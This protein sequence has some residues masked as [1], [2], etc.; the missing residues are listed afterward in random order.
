MAIGPIKTSELK[1]RILQ[2]AQTSVYQIKLSPPAAVLSHLRQNGFDYAADG[3]NMEL[4]CNSAV[5]PGSSLKTHDIVGDFQGV[6]EKMAYQRMYDES[7]DLTFYV[8]HDYK[9]I[10]LFDGWL[11]YISGQGSGQRLSK[12][13]ALKPSANYRMNYPGYGGDIGYKTNMSIVKF[14]KDVSTDRSIFEDDK[15]FQ[16]TYT[17]VNAFPKTIVSTPISYEGNQ[18]LKYS[19]SMSIQRYV[20]RVDRIRSNRR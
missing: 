1:S 13:D 12:N 4:L 20:R 19:V 10:N 3:E 15:T 18:I 6:S 8:D 17:L 2:L 9:V 14:E 7:V 16:L 11:D 5:L